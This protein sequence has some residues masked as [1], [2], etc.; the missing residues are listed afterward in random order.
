[1]NESLEFV[2]VTTMWNQATAQQQTKKRSVHKPNQAS[3]MLQYE[4]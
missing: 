1:M 2:G 4:I 3:S